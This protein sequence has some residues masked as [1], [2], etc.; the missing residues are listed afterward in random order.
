M[1]RRMDLWP[2]V[3]YAALASVLGVLFSLVVGRMLVAAAEG[4]RG[5]VLP[6]LVAVAFFAALVVFMALFLGAVRKG[7]G[8]GS[9]NSFMEKIIGVAFLLVFLAVCAAFVSVLY[10][11]LAV[12]LQGLLEGSVQADGLKNIVSIVSGVLTVL[13]LPV[14]VAML[15]GY[16]D[17]DGGVLEGV[18]GGLKSL[19]RT[20]WKL[21]LVLAVGAV[22]GGLVALVFGP[23]GAF[24]L[25]LVGRALV[26]S[27]VGTV[28]LWLCANVCRPDKGS[29]QLQ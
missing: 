25:A 8:K 5:F 14:F 21:F 24:G 26:L 3:L 20:Y 19:R 28:C 9:A 13:V 4:K 29:E 6:V 10:G 18:R 15:F 12:L 2:G 11:L 17:S 27:I 1:G 7:A 22:P 16:G 23:G